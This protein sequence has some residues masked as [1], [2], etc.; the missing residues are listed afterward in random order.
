MRSS[1]PAPTLTFPLRSLH[2]GLTPSNPVSAAPGPAK[3]GLPRERGRGEEGG[4]QVKERARSRRATRPCGAGAGRTGLRS[5]SLLQMR[6]QL[7]Q[8]WLRLS[9]RQ[10]PRSPRIREKSSRWD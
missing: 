10:C 7:L 9:G 6:W 1:P 8:L 4:M 5:G 3:L 2:P